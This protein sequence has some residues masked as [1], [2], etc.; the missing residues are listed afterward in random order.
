VSTA[1]SRRQATREAIMDSALDLFAE[2]GYESVRVEDV[3]R[4]AG[5]SRATFYNHFSEREEILGGLIERLLAVDGPTPLPDPDAPPLEQIED[6]AAAA[7]GTMLK[8]PELA[9]FIYGLPVRHEALL[10]PQ[11]AATPAVFRTIH[12]LLEEAESRGELRPDMP[13][14]L[15]CVHVHNALEA[16]MRAWAEGTAPDAAERVRSLV[17]LALYG[18]VARPS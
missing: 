14:D 2:R 15:M 9:R 11:S 13:V 16:G 4:A 1:T 7:A 3:A 5:I 6:V 18:V 17:R 10:K 8:Q 12:H